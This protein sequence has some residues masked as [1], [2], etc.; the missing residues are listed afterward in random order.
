MF[1]IVFLC[2][3]RLLLTLL[4]IGLRKSECSAQHIKWNTWS[5]FYWKS[6]ANV[7]LILA[8]CLPGMSCLVLRAVQLVSAGNLLRWKMIC[9]LC[10]LIWK[11]TLLKLFFISVIPIFLLIYHRHLKFF[12]MLQYI[13]S[14]FMNFI[15]FY[16]CKTK[17]L[18]IQFY[19]FP[20]AVL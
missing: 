16:M 14:T 19:A 17:A 5:S 9:K 4:S 10:S 11:I 18:K 6:R 3:P 12:W 2:H 13:F 1:L 8:W 7:A 20:P 15:L